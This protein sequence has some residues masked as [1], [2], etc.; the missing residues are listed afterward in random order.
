M[1]Q[2]SGSSWCQQFVAASSVTQV[3]YSLHHAF[4]SAGTDACYDYYATDAT[5]LGVLRNDYVVRVDL[6]G[7]SN[8]SAWGDDPYLRIEREILSPPRI[9]LREGARE[10]AKALLRSLLTAAEWEAYVTHSKLV[11]RGKSGRCYTI[12]NAG[13]AGNIHVMDEQGRTLE[14]LCCHPGHGENLPIEDVILT[15]KLHLEHNEDAFRALANIRFLP[16]RAE[17]SSRLAL[18]S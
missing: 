2:P 6:L 5:T 17:A 12:T 13:P 7:A 4:G 3:H 1:Q 18:A 15:Q 8:V 9:E 16:Q 14:T 10:K 11:V